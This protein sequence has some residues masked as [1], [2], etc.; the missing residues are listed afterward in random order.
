MMR[1][2]RVFETTS[3]ATLLEY[4]LIAGLVIAASLGAMDALGEGLQAT[5][6]VAR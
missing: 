6:I 1:L 4:G 5:V 2:V 3:G